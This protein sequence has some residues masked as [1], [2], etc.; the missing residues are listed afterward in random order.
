MNNNTFILIGIFVLFVGMVIWRQYKKNHWLSD[1]TKEGIRQYKQESKDFIMAFLKANEKITSKNVQ[2]SL[3]MPETM[4][5][6]LLEELRKKA[7][8]IQYKKEG[9]ETYYTKRQS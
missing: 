1:Q 8:I 7:R 5:T 9:E 3:S 4:S 2:D 6:K